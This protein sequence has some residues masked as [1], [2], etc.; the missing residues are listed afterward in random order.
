LG[1]K[2]GSGSVESKIKQVAARVKLSGARWKGDNVNCLDNERLVEALA[3]V[4]PASHV[5][6]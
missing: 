6:V 1:I 4:K 5:R 3:T 2:I